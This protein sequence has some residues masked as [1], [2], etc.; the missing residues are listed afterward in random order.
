MAPVTRFDTG[1]MPCRLGAELDDL[2]AVGVL[3]PKLAR[4]H[5]RAITLGMMAA[6]QA[7]EDAGLRKARWIPKR[8]GLIEG[9]SLGNVETAYKGRISYDLRGY[10]GVS[11]S[12]MLDGHIGGGSAQT[13]L[14]L[15][16]KRFAQS[17]STSSASG[18]DVLG[19][20]LR[21]IRN[22]E[23]DLVL[24]G[25]A[26]APLIDTVWA[27]FCQLRVLTRADGEPSQA[28][29]AFDKASDGFALGEGAAYLVVE[30]LGHALARGARIYAELTG[31]GR[32]TEAHH[33]MAPQEDGSGVRRGMQA[34]SRCS[35]ARRHRGHDPDTRLRQPDQRRSRVPCHP[36]CFRAQGSAGSGHCY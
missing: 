11:P 6:V 8:A 33:S 19:A 35:T 9:T 25:A 22:N 7:F 20:A 30:E 1:D 3:G 26:E 2:D 32:S 23:A 31:Y 36:R 24:A 28:V 13:A 27:G 14:L 29:R 17:T 10:R 16:L 18:G 34:A 5:D 15:G 4:K 21:A 12:A